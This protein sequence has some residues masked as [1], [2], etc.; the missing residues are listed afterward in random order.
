MPRVKATIDPAKL[1]HWKLLREFRLRLAAAQTGSL[2]A[3]PDED[4][5]RKLLQEDYFSLF[6]F[7]LL[8]PVVTTMRGLCAAS[9]FER[10]QD[11]VCGRPVSLGS[12][13]EAQSIFDPDLLKEVFLSL[14]EETKKPWGDARL[15]HLADK[16]QVVDGTL[17]PALA[18][19]HWALWMDEENRAAKLH[20]KFKV[21]RQAASDALITTGKTCE[22]KALRRFVK[23]GEI[24]VGDRYYGLDYG[25]LDELRQM[26]VSFVLRIR[27]KP[28]MD[29]VEELPLS[30]ADRSAGVTWQGMVKLGDDWQGQPVRV[31]KVE[32]DGKTL[33]LATDLNIEAELIALIY[34]YRWQIEL[35]FKWIKQHLRIKAFYGTTP[36]AVKTQI[37]IA[38]SVYVVVAIVKKELKI[39]RSLYEILQILSVT[40]FEKT[41][42]FEALSSKNY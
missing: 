26:L 18:R 5:K 1:S 31:V 2:T 41:P 15:S 17:L 16:L 37:W 40:L 32:V 34:R 4:P 21:L 7:G 25:F 24:I 30:S 6:L 36:N 14:S 35:F 13:S 38:I 27:N 39:E 10:V 29:I 8:N 20:L 3:V 11:E 9:K 23:K 42:I 19:M 12:F 33:L 22:R 28:N